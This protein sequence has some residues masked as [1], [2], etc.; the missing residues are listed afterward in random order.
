MILDRIT[1]DTKR[2]N[3]QP[4][5]RNLRLTVRRVLE[6]LSTYPDRGEL[7]EEYPELEEEDIRQVLLFSATRLEDK[8]I[9]LNA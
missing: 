6:V 7:F 8:V 4:C 2:M 9:S 1:T 3:G 5:V